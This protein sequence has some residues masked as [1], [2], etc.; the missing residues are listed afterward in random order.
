V[1][2]NKHLGS[3]LNEMYIKLSGYTKQRSHCIIFVSFP[4]I[5]SHGNLNLKIL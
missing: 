3:V 1:L 5:T 4:K 2:K